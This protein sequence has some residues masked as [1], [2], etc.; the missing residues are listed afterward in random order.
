MRSHPAF[1]L[2]CL[3]LVFSLSLVLSFS[4]AQG[5]GQGSVIRWQYRPEEPIIQVGFGGEILPMGAQNA[6][7][8]IRIPGLE[9][10]IIPGEPVIPF[11][12]ARILIPFGEEIEDIKVLPGEKKNLGKI[13]IEPGQ[14][15]CP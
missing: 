8:S 13:L 7:K 2:T 6:T 9:N 10:R 3:L 14:D 5:Y 12:T 15:P 1:C 11:R 4:S